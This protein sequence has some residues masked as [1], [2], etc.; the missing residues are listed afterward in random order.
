MDWTIESVPE[1]NGFTVEWAEEGNFYLSRRNILYRSENLKP[2]FKK[3]A[4]VAAPF[5]K[6]AASVSRLAQRLLRF[7]VTNVVPLENG[8]LFVTFDKSV[9]LVRGG[10]FKPLPGL[11]R[12]CRVLRAACARDARGDIYFGEYLANDERGEM[13][14]YKFAAGADALEIA[15]TF[16]ANS[17][18]HIHGIYA[19]EF[20]NS[21]VCLTGDDERECRMIRSFD[22]FRT[23]EV[24]GEGDETWRAVSILFDEN[25]FYY[26]MDAEFRANHIYKVDRNGGARKSLGEVNGTVFYSKR[27]AGSLFFTT[28]AENAPSQTENVA[29]LWRID[30][31]EFCRKVVSFEKDFW[32]PTLFQFG[33]IHFPFQNKLRNELYFH[34]VGVKEDNRTFRIRAKG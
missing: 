23:T 2:P 27:L 32:H 34:L 14:I 3:I 9:G 28:T 12:P 6:Q 4:A 31:N 13:R 30:E 11:K 17:I 10:E 26:G 18:K 1:L 16:P 29:A 7:Q 20:T 8:D 19:D 24:I 21:M 5:W 22:G 25:A 33:T 15:H